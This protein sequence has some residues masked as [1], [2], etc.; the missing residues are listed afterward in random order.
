MISNKNMKTK[1][2]R[3]NGNK[4]KLKTK[5]RVTSMMKLYKI[6]NAKVLQTTRRECASRRRVVTMMQA[7][8]KNLKARRTSK[9]R[10]FNYPTIK[11]A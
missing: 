3:K 5:V 8:R 7:S 4:R 9:E 1:R 6:G 11:L 10:V 2:R